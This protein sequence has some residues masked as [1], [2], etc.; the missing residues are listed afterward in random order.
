[1]LE[2]LTTRFVRFERAPG[3]IQWNTSVHARGPVTLPI[4]A[5]PAPR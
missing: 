2:E 1:M 4:R 5:I 3:E